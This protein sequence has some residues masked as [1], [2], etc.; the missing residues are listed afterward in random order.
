MSEKNPF[1]FDMIINVKYKKGWKEVF[2]LK[3]RESFFYILFG[4]HI[5]LR[6]CSFGMN[7]KCILIYILQYFTGKL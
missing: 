1:S 5:T 4:A 7:R 6:V 3:R 2:K